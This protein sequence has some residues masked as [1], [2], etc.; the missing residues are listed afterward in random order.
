MQLAMMCATVAADLALV[1]LTHDNP[2]SVVARGLF[3]LGALG[4]S[5][6]SGVADRH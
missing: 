6:A 4:L 5:M 2:L 3:T 1:L